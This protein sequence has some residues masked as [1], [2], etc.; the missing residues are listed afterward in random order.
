MDDTRLVADG[1]R[2]PEG[3][4]VLADGSLLAVE[5][6][7][8]AVVRIASDGDIERIAVPG[9]PNGLALGPDGKVYVCNNGGYLMTELGPM[10]IPGVEPG[11]VTEPEGF[12]GGSI[13]RLDLDSGEVETLYTHCNG[14]RLR[15]PNDLVFDTAGGFWF[16]DHGKVRR[17]D[18]DRGA[19]YYATADGS[20]IVEAAHSLYQPNGVGLSPDGSRVY[21]AETP[22]GRLWQW[23]VIG[24][25]EV[26]RAVPWGNGGGLLAGVGGLQ[27]FDSLGV[28]EGGRVCVATLVNP[29]ITV[30]TPDGDVEHLPLPGEFYDPLPT[31]IAWGGDDMRTAYITLSATGRVM[32]CRWPRPGLRLNF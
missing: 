6:A 20:T 7:G 1:L 15:A 31:N 32:A 18:M 3:P 8:A 5:M 9:A 12:Q 2:F 25:G 11:G 22:T 24:P 19:L 27:F 10:L 16:T 28:E 26:S 21:V 30:V 4:T 14:V 29:G 13:Q 17:H 23:D